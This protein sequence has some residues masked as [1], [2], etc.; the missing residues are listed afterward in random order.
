MYTVS[1]FTIHYNTI[2]L[3]NPFIMCFVDLYVGIIAIN[4]ISFSFSIYN[5][6]GTFKFTAIENK[7][8]CYHEFA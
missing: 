7:Q 2:T 3:K 6:H 5:S 4:K 1:G 8:D